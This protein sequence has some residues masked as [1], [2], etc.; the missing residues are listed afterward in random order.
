MSMLLYNDLRVGMWCY[1]IVSSLLASV[2]CAEDTEDTTVGS[3]SNRFMEM[4]ITMK[5]A[6]LF[7]MLI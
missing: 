3:L 6:I 4:E 5:R 1:L 7:H 2:A